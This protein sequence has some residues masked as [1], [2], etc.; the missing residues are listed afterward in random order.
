MFVVASARASFF[1]A[2]VPWAIVP[3]SARPPHRTG[4]QTSRLTKTCYTPFVAHKNHG[5]THRGT[6]TVPLTLARSRG[7]VWLVLLLRGDG[8]D[9]TSER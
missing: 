2:R 5:H 3:L 8:Q 6:A 1:V 7:A 4:T 9:T